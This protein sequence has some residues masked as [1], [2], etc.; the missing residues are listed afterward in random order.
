MSTF[1]HGVASCAAID[2]AGEIVDIKGLDITSLDKTG[3]VNY[4]HDTGKTPDGQSII[5]KIP[6]QLVGKILKA[7]KIFTLA[8]CSDEHETYFWN[9]T[10]LPFVYI[11]AELLDDYCDSARN[12]AGALKYSKDHPEQQG[13]Y[14][15]SV[16]GSE[17]PGTRQQK[18][19]IKRSIAR[20]VT[21][22]A[23]PA[24]KACVA[25]I[26][27]N[28][29]SQIKDEFEEI[30]KSESNAI[31][32]FKTEQGLKIYETYLAKKE[33]ELKKVAVPGSKYPS[34][35]AAVGQK[36]LTTSGGIPKFAPIE[37]EPSKAPMGAPRSGGVP[38]FGPITKEPSLAPVDAPKSGGVPSFGP[39]TKKEKKTKDLK[40]AITAGNYNAA[41]GTLVNG[42]AYQV[43]DRGNKKDWNKRAKED[44]EKWP[45]RE[46]FEKFVQSRM[47][48]LALGE[49]KALGRVIA[50]KKNI[51]F[52][53]SLKELVSIN[54]S[55]DAKKELEEKSLKDIQIETA[56]KWADRAEEA[57]KKA[58]DQKSVK[59]LLDAVEYGHEAI[60]HA[61][62][63]EEVSVFEDIKSK[64]MPLHDKAVKLL[65]N[66]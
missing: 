33:K 60:E 55:E 46:K 31:E 10:K 41:P 24:N 66:K 13:I 52:E 53:K 26:L 40:K 58:I 59:W 35:A 21:L 64:I 43:E 54:K 11:V 57:Y 63:C 65:A 7:K 39:I 6:A 3:V 44:Y 34:A 30:F 12:A 8:D 47:P 38:S 23:A 36:P 56:N 62:L 16:E 51:N 4:E 42:A 14:G 45:Q 5:V 28:Q 20:K 37:K 18:I 27:D 2:T 17:I 19:L 48:H 1:I 49:I 22:T 32:M 15:F 61:S 25:E 50:L 9:R 29:P